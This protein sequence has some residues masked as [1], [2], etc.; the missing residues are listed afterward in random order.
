LTDGIDGP[1][2]ARTF[3]E[4]FSDPHRLEK[5]S[6]GSLEVAQE[7]DSTT[8]TKKMRSRNEILI[9]DHRILTKDHRPS[10]Y[11]RF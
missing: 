4:L 5:L 9:N 1:S 11:R 6:Q 8:M 2:L 10:P 3:N 7:F